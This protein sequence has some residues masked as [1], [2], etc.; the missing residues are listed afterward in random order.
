[1]VKLVGALIRPVA[2]GCGSRGT[3]VGWAGAA[4]AGRR[5]RELVA[6]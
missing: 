3:S 4:G 6:A 5:Q 1:M 2:L